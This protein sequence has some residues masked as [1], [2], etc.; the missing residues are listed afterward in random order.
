[1][2]VHSALTKNTK[3]LKTLTKINKCSSLLVD[4]EPYWS[5]IRKWVCS[6]DFDF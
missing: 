3:I 2:Q 6:T 1:M 5:V 4:N